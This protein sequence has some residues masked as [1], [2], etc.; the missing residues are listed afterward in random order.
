MNG[1]VVSSNSERRLEHNRGSAPPEVEPVHILRGV[2]SLSIGF[3][4]LLDSVQIPVHAPLRLLV[5]EQ[6]VPSTENLLALALVR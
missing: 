4:A 6:V 3:P 5:L 1:Q 2:G